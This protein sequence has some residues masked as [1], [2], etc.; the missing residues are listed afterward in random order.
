M[1]HSSLLLSFIVSVIAATSSGQSIRVGII[2]LDTSHA[3]AFSQVLNSDPQPPEVMGAR[4]VAAYPQGSRD[5]ESSTQRV[6]ELTEKV[7]ANGVE[8]VESI[9]ALLDRVDVVLL[10]SNDGRPHLEQLRP[11][12]EAGK[13]TFIDK[14]VAGSLA[15]AIKIYEEAKEARVP[16]FSSSSL[17]FGFDTQEVMK[18]SIGA[19]KHAETYSPAS[20]EP[21]HPDLFWYGIHG[22]EAL[23]SVLGSECE[24][25]Q[26]GTTEDGRI[27]VKG[28]WS[29][30]RT[31]V[32]RESA[33]TDKPRFGGV[34]QG[35]KGQA[36][37]GSFDGY[38]PLLHRIVHFFRTGQAPVAPGET[39][40][41][42]AFMEA[43]DESARQGGAVVKISEVME[44][45]RGAR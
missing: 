5:I 36:K 44:K 3:A 26:R 32:F 23:F 21:T 11:C 40:A 38:E 2:G 29:G 30:G 6:P 18:G 7:K 33:A 9:D 12:L 14:P 17:R 25:V 37:I 45:A 10:E 27:E 1:R 22:V 41:I 34:A 39:L 20:L 24:T 16:V 42:Y 8:I 13:P 19:V 43:A 31:G 35:E 4:V 28:T 15:D